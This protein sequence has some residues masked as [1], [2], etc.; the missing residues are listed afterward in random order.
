VTINGTN[1][2]TMFDE[3]AP[4][5]SPT[6]TGTLTTPAI[7][8]N[9][10]NL[11]TTLT[12]M[13]NS[14]NAKQ[15]Q[16][17]SLN[18]S[19]GTYATAL[20]NQKQILTDG[21][22]LIIQHNNF[23]ISQPGSGQWLDLLETT[24]DTVSNIATVSTPGILTANLLLATTLNCM[25]SAT[26]A[27]NTNLIGNLSVTGF[28][29]HKPYVAL[30]VGSNG[31]INANVGYIPS[32]QITISIASSNAYTIAFPAHPNGSNFLVHVDYKTGASS[33]ALYIP[34]CNNS[35]TSINVWLRSA[36]NTIHTGNFY[37]HTVP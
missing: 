10:T 37:V 24:W 5:A 4:K 12:N 9:G 18:Y 8:L 14:I 7:T 23:S 6:F 1:L 13:D 25:G 2:L 28:Y 16:I 22:R 30:L 19:N 32:E 20:G 29:P 33:N 15:N 36:T 3:R 34:T 31:A 27:G 35:Q 17:Q 21:P 11:A 26:V